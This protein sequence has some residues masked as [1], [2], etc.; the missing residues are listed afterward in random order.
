MITV[1]AGLSGKYFSATV[2]DVELAV[3]GSKA[4]VAL[5]VAGEEVFKETL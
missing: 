4:E 3:T 2:P 5:T 1:T